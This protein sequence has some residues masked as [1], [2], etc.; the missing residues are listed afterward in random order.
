[1]KIA[2]SVSGKEKAQEA[3][4]PY[5]KALVEA[6]AR[7][8]ELRLITCADAAGIRAEDFD[9]IL[10][11]GGEDVDPSFYDEKK[12]YDNVRVNPARDE[13]EFSLLDRARRH[14]TPVFG[15]CRGAQMVN[16]RFGGTLYQDIKSDGISGGGEAALVEHKQP[17]GRADLSHSVTVTDP[18]SRLAQV[19]QGSFRVNSLHHQGIKRLGRGLKVCAH[20]EDGLVEAVEAADDDSYLLAV[21]WHPEELTG[22]TEHRRLL[23]RFIQECRSN[24]ARHEITKALGK[25]GA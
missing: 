15:I 14:R 10:F 20:A 21:Q 23:E 13:F 9:G 8:E 1:M 16:V 7:S 6:G 12:K 17:G 2:I 11:A 18:G 19:L 22:H 25:A 4:S 5:F 24:A 3:N